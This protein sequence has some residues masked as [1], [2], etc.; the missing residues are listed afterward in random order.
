MCRIFHKNVSG[1]VCNLRHASSMITVD[2]FVRCGFIEYIDNVFAK[3]WTVENA[4]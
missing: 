4:K 1:S 3:G 2:L